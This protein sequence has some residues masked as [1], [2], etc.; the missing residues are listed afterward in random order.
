MKNLLR[1]SLA[2]F[3]L[4]QS[5]VAL[6]VF[7]TFVVEQIF[8]NA[9]GTVQF[10]VLHEDRNANG[11]HLVGG[12][13]LTASQSGGTRSFV[14]PSHLPSTATAGRRVLIATPGFTAL[15]LVTPI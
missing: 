11:Q 9:S 15:G 2:A 13:T 6:G 4:V 10:I 5:S 14:F 3:L 12:H 1:C 7:H 8:S